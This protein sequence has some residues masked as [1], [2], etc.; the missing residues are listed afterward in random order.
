MAVY[1]INGDNIE[2]TG[3][4]SASIAAY[5]DIS[6]ASGFKNAFDAAMADNS[7][8]VLNIPFGTYSVSSALRVRSNVEIN[9]NG[10]RL[11]VNAETNIFVFS[12]VSNCYV[13]DFIIDMNQTKDTQ[14]GTALYILDS[15]KI[16]MRNIQILN[17]GLRACLAYTS[18][19]AETGHNDYLLWDNV[20]MHGIG[21]ENTNFWEWPCAIIAV[22]CW[23][24]HIRNC[25]VT[26]MSRF[27]LEFKNHCYYCTMT[28]NSIVGGREGL[29]FGGDRPD[30]VTVLGENISVSD[31]HVVGCEYPIHVNRGKDILFS[32]NVL[33]GECIFVQESKSIVID[34]NII[35][36]GEG[37]TMSAIKV[38]AGD[39][40][41]FTNNVYE[42]KD[43][44]IPLYR[45]LYGEPTNIL[46][47]GFHKGHYINIESPEDGMD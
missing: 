35:R 31:N 13:H 28:G 26:G 36:A 5:G 16:T 12:N 38:F 6:T 22:N 2:T 44:S 17:I 46:L 7:I 10:S 47:S 41:M 25:T 19:T 33:D 42:K 23:H 30:D 27:T 11:N 15:S 29:C 37:D 9:G 32:N 1:N 24:S 34:G 8:S 43:P 21:E 4:N 39:T 3:N 40:L 14:T 18:D 45:Y 20:S